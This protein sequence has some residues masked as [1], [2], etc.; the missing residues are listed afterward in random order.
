MPR[1]TEGMRAFSM[2]AESW[3][4]AVARAQKLLVHCVFFMSI[5]PVSIS[6]PHNP[7]K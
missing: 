5:T 4:A 3:K 7:H 1:V 6:A 2:W